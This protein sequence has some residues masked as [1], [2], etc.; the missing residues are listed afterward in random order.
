MHSYSKLVADLFPYLMNLGDWPH[1]HVNS[2]LNID[3]LGLSRGERV[4]LLLGDERYFVNEG[5]FL[6]EY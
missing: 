4:V 5:S 2:F 1:L 3:H 6:V